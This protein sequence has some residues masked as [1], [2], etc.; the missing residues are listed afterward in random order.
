MK[1]NV[2]PAKVDIAREGDSLIF[3]LDHPQSGNEI[4]G[5]MFEDMLHSLRAE[6]ASPT[7][8]VLRIRAQGEVFCR[9]RERA[10]RDATAIRTEVA[11][12]IALK[13]AIRETAMI[14]VAEVQGD[15]AGF[16]IGLAVLC[17]FTLVAEHATLSFPEMRKG[18]PPA[19]IMAY[20]GQYAL[21]KHIFPLILLADD[22]TPARALEIGLITTVCPR[23][24]LRAQAD[25]LVE[26]ILAMDP[27]GTRQCKAYFLAAQ[28]QS[29]DSNFRHATD[30]LTVQTLR[31]QAHQS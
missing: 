14:S 18:L 13:Q 29:M 4:T 21:P 9:G 7:A 26:R 30:L 22:F 27:E 28:A 24:T 15:A 11:R 8:Q 12:L 25:R 19:A 6:A 31:L 23:D 20:L 16:G 17:D 1:D 3:T 2:S 10:G 5:A